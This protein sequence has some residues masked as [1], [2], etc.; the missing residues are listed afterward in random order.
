EG[1]GLADCSYVDYSG[2]SDVDE[3]HCQVEVG[4]QQPADLQ[5]DTFPPQTTSAN[6]A[7]ISP[8]SSTATLDGESQDVD[9]SASTASIDSPQ[10]EH[11]R[12]LSANQRPPN[13]ADNA[14]TIDQTD[15]TSGENY[16]DQGG[17][18]SPPLLRRDEISRDRAGS[19]L[20]HTYVT[21]AD[22]P[23]SGDPAVADTGATQTA[24]ETRQSRTTGQN[25]HGNNFRTQGETAVSAGASMGQSA[26]V[27]LTTKRNMESQRQQ[28][29]V[30]KEEEDLDIANSL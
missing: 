15:S 25:Q 19:D 22:P 23:P 12:A 1:D 21:V 28:S 2:N 8:H 17:S 20:I 5:A 11:S 30:E 9:D 26:Y 7:R 18:C 14:R 29:M 6:A 10:P 27:T 24:S 16:C 4:V 3:D 13:A